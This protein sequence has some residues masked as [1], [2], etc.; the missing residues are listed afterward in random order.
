MALLKKV[1]HAK[2]VS[3]C[4][5]ERPVRKNTTLSKNTCDPMPIDQITKNLQPALQNFCG[6]TERIPPSLA[7]ASFAMFRL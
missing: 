5:V 7:N 2:A 1:A 3:R 4:L 6:V